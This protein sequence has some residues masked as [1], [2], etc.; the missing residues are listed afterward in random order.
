M[1]GKGLT[2]SVI[3]AAA[4]EL[5]AERGYNK[6]TV[7][8]LAQRLECRAASL[9]NYIGSFDDVN[10]EV[11][12]MAARQMNEALMAASDGKERDE[13]VTALAH[14]YRRFA[15][16]HYELYQAIMGLPALDQEESLQVG[17]ETFLVIRKVVHQYAISDEDAVNFS[18]CLRGALH[19]FVSYEMS[20]YYT[21]Q[22]VPVEESFDFLIRGYIEWVRRLEG[23]G[24]ADMIQERP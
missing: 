5:V 21:S 22:Y 12:K 9:Y 24:A 10:R 4:A 2:M 20:G 16:E 15:K 8:E 11:G 1:R 19:G 13:A 18:R 7:R 6:F 17:R 14:E 3:S 23:A